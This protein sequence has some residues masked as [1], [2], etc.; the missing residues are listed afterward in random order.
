MSERYVERVTTARALDEFLSLGPQPEILRR[1]LDPA[2]EPFWRH[3]ACELFVLRHGR[4]AVGRVAAI[5]NTEHDRTHRDGA[6]FFG[7]IVC[8]D[9]VDAARSL[10]EAAAQWLRERGYTRMRGPIHLGMGEEIGLLLDGFERP[11]GA[12]VPWNPPYLPRLLERV[13]LTIVHER[14]GF[15]WSRDEVP[16]PPASLRAPEERRGTGGGITYRPL[17]VRRPDLEVQ[18]FLAT[19]NTAYAGRWG[20]VPLSEEEARARLRDVIVFG[21]ARLVWMAEV[22]GQPAG[23]VVTLPVVPDGATLRVAPAGRPRLGLG[24]GTLRALREALAMSRLERA[25]LVAIAVEPRFRGL[26]IGAQLLLRAWRAA[27]DLG[28]REA[29]LSGVDPSDDVML[30]MLWRLGCRR[31]RRFGVAELAWKR[32]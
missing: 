17:D 8:P 22:D 12:L 10:I 7:W 4:K 16:P 24:L 29:E 27:L 30:H 3:A 21:D 5:A 1:R 32:S 9:D 2:E 23:V 19:Y 28:V 13:G 25:H 20:F 18:R 6:G 15:A 26:H 14:Q 11:A 31:V